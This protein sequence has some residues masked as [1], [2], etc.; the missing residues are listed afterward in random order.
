MERWRG[1]GAAAGLGERSVRI[2]QRTD[3]C[4]VDAERTAPQWSGTVSGGRRGGDVEGVAV[5][6]D[7]WE[8]NGQE[9]GFILGSW[10]YTGTW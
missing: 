5:R 6:C 9:A 7:G 3:A 10:Y 1:G 2:K 4:H 8:G